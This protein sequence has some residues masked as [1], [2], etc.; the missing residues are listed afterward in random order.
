MTRIFYIHV[1]YYIVEVDLTLGL[2]FRRVRV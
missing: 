2:S 1:V